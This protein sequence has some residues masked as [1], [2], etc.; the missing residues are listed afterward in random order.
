MIQRPLHVIRHKKDNHQRADR[1]KQCRQNSD[2]S[3]S[4][5]IITIVINHHDN[6]I[7]HDSER[8]GNTRQR[9]QIKLNIKQVI[10]DNGYQYVG[11][12]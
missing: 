6:S 7:Y 10:K 3:T 2:K 8:D 11:E 12:Q 9:D 1:G 5:V 4:I